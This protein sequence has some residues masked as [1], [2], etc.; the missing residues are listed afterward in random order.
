M[1][2][3]GNLVQ[4]LKKPTSAANHYGTMNFIPALEIC[5][6]IAN[7]RTRRRCNFKE[8]S[9]VGG[10]R[11]FLKISAPFNF[12]GSIKP[13]NTLKKLQ[14]KCSFKMQSSGIESSLFS[15]Y[16]Y[17]LTMTTNV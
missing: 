15:L 5:F 2:K 13:G 4:P 1:W 16:F 17:Q 6:R 11:I 10:R 8:L 12:A 14:I 3:W 7:S 9:Q